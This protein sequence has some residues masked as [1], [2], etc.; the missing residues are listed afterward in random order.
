MNNEAIKNIANKVIQKS[1]IESQDQDRFGNPLMILAVISIILTLVRIIQE[2]NKSKI[3]LFDRKSK[4]EF[5]QQQI[6]DISIRRSWFTKMTVKKALR[7][8]LDRSDYQKY[9]VSLLESI[10]SVGENLTPQEV[11]ALVEVSDV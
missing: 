7:K 2:C 3:K 6:K 4:S 5:F 10:L 9:G 8:E 1:N 11:R